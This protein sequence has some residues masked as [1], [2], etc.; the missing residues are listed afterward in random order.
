[1]E[2]FK[3]LLIVE[4]LVDGRSEC[5][6]GCRWEELWV[7]VDS[8]LADLLNV[9]EMTLSPKVTKQNQRKVTQQVT[10]DV[11]DVD[12]NAVQCYTFHL[13]RYDAQVSKSCSIILIS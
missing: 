6:L 9:S 7:Q 8:T 13:Q 1:V 2:L 10:I 3:R 11:R 4:V 5:L 12:K